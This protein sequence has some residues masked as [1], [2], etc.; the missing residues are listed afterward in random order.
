MSGF[1]CEHTRSLHV[2]CVSPSQAAAKSALP[3]F[4]TEFEHSNFQV[5]Q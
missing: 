4:A 1:T 5:M 3:L 2:N